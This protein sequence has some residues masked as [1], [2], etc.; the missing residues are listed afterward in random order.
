MVT[1]TGDPSAN[2]FKFY[3]D[4]NTVLFYEFKVQIAEYLSTLKNTSERTLADLIAFNIE[5]CSTEMRYFGQEVFQLAEATSG[6]LQDPVY[7][8]ARAA[9]LDFARNGINLALARGDLDAIVAPTSALLHRPLL[10]PDIRTFLS[11]SDLLHKASRLGFGC[12]AD[13]LRNQR[14]SLMPSISSRPFT[15][16][17]NRNSAAP[18]RLSLPMRTSAISRQTRLRRCPRPVPQHVCRITSER[19]NHCLNKSRQCGTVAMGCSIARA[20]AHWRLLADRT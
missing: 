2:N 11:R 8:A 5:H 14:S 16:E 1:D 12:T 6:N 15:R 13:I 17:H 4:E 20:A 18:S 3:N 7:L 19:V 10:S 9:N